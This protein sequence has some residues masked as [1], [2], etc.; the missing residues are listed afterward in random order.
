MDSS[1]SFPHPPPSL[2]L[3][4][5]PEVNY[6]PSNPPLSDTPPSNPRTPSVIRVTES[7][8]DAQY[9]AIAAMPDPRQR[10]HRRRQVVRDG[11]VIKF[12]WLSAGL[13]ALL[14]LFIMFSILFSI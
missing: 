9:R 7:L 10:A 5:Y 3:Y 11:Y 14:V 12:M 4:T 6:H 2:P 8:T 13:A 1:L